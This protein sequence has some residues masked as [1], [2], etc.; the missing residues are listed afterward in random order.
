[1]KR[2]K[3]FLVGAGP[4][5][6]KLITIRAL[7]VLEEAE[8][9]VY[10][11][12]VPADILKHA[13]KAELIYVG[14]SKGLHTIPQEI[15]NEILLKEASKGKKVVRLKGGDPYVFGRGGEELIYLRERGIEVEYIPGITSAIAVPGVCDIPLTHRG[16]SSS[17]AIVTGH[18]DPTKDSS[19]RW[20][21]LSRAVDTL[22]ILMGVGR[23]EKIV[24]EMRM[25]GETMVGIIE[26]GY[27]KEQRIITCKL[28]D[29]VETVKR[30]KI[31]PPSIFVFG[32]VVKIYEMVR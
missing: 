20:A 23:I 26:K 15:I 32:D 27:S 31:K 4:G 3:V 6:P 9:V 14:K 12:L 2:G 21:E 17:L 22:V 24:N 16:F 5:D 7:E 19:I 30:E 28:K 29:L 11:R 8:V 18:Q 1:M 13:K 25:D 10:D